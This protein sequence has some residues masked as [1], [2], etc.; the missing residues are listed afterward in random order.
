MIIFL[1]MLVL[2]FMGY[3][4]VND[5]SFVAMFFTGTCELFIELLFVYRLFCS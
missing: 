1:M 3:H 2:L 5:P 4:D